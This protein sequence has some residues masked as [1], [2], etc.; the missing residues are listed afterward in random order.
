MIISEKK[1]AV[2]RLAWEQAKEAYRIRKN[3]FDQ[4]LEKPSDLLMAEYKKEKKELEYYQSVYEY[5]SATVY[6]QFLK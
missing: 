3:R 2:T 1:T 6:Y 5:N 4:G